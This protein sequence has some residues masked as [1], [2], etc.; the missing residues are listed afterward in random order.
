M[1]NGV[2]TVRFDVLDLSL[3]N[4]YV[5]QH[6]ALLSKLTVGNNPLELDFFFVVGG[7]FSPILLSPYVHLPIPNWGGLLII[8]NTS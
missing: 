6:F 7:L 5:I 1:S 2:V 4:G 8:L 3:S